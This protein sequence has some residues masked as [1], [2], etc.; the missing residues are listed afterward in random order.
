MKLGILC[1][2]LLLGFQLQAQTK[3]WYFFDKCISKEESRQQLLQFGLEPVVWSSWFNSWSAKSEGIVDMAGVDSVWLVTPLEMLATSVARPTLGFALEQ[4]GAK[5]IV[6]EGLTGKGVKIGIIDGGFLGAHKSDALAPLIEA[7]QPVA[8]RSYLE[9]NQNDPF[10]G[11]F[12]MDDMHGT[13]VWELT[14]GYH[15]RKNIQFGLAT[16][17]SYYL[18]RTDHGA[19]EERQE[20]DFL[21]A[22]LEWLDSLEVRLV[23]ISL[24]YNTGFDKPGEDY[25]KEMMDGKTALASLA[26]QKASDEKGMLIVVAAGNDGHNDWQIVDVPADPPGVLTVGATDLKFWRK[27]P[28]SSIGTD[29]TPF[30]KPE[31][32]CF[33]SAGTSFA[34]PV[35]T[36]L[37]ACIWEKDPTLTNV[38]IK[39]LIM[40]SGHLSA[41]PNN[42]IGHG[43]PDA[44]WL[45]E[46]LSTGRETWTASGKTPTTPAKKRA[47]V[48]LEGEG[49][50]QVVLYHK[51]DR[52]HVVSEEFFTYPG[53]SLKIKAK[54]GVKFTTVV[55]NHQWVMEVEWLQ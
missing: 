15:Q 32:S 54:P 1:L 46:K 44:R 25:T 5:R 13:E 19:R 3:Y 14:G 28:F 2:F 24:G 43:V 16:G 52:Q 29:F 37:A 55:V 17:A 21:I 50:K 22:A 51:K 47:E 18:A 7:G 4:I 35:I 10:G 26:C 27:M 20:E 31:V 40:Q 41:A 53:V 39:Q 36:G 6:E 11:S 8:F 38:E 30:L 45:L 42:Y 33:A 12:A 34:A 48:M 9:P 23:N 49:S